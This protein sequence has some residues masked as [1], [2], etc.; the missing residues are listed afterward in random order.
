MNHQP[1]TR[2]LVFLQCATVLS[3]LGVAAWAYAATLEVQDDTESGSLNELLGSDVLPTEVGAAP[4]EQLHWLLVER[5]R[6]DFAQTQSITT[7]LRDE[8]LTLAPQLH[9]P[10]WL[11]QLE[12]RAYLARLR[13]GV[14]H[15]LQEVASGVGYDIP[16]AEHALVDAYI[17]YFSGRGREFFTKWLGRAARYEPI[18]RPILQQ[19]GLPQ[20]IIYLAMIESGLSS[21]A[22]SHAKA[23]GFWQFM[24]Q[25][26]RAYKLSST[27]WV[28]ARS[29]FI[30]ATHA[31]ATYL[32][33]L[34]KEFDDWHL[35][36]AAYNGGRGR[37]S[38]ALARTGARDFWEL[39]NYPQ[40]L[41]QE[42]RH[43]VPK[44]I[45][46][47]IVA[48]NA[49]QYGFNN[50]EPLSPLHYDEVTVDEPVD[51]HLVA[52]SLGTSVE[53]LRTLNPSLLQDVTP[54]GKSFA[55]RVPRGRG[56]ETL[57]WLAD[58]PASERLRYHAHT[59]AVGESLW[60]VAR[61]YGT[62]VPAI[63]EFNGITNPKRLRPGM[64]LI[65]P[66]PRDKRLPAVASG[67]TT[68][69][70]QAKASTGNGTPRERHVVGPGETLW[71]I[72]RRYGVSVDRL[73]EWN[74]RDGNAIVVGETLEIF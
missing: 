54:P 37:V 53:E 26:A 22:L 34:H 38:R 66:T 70:P 31:A 19:H 52:R 58:L 14:H 72:S 35:A 73:R 63:R 32:T 50:V 47:A 18:M 15:S 55:L 20:D 29:D 71:A 30:E 67:G 68:K 2:H 5:L 43:Y 10:H 13:G 59:L 46:A 40:A 17:D 6:T 44:I 60:T 64:T 9:D 12:R 57:A 23:G 45:A 7:R 11:A 48:K 3:C 49:Q 33:Y 4:Q 8:S 62:R 1:T 16:L 69:R 42:T 41:P 39:L 56:E 24:P 36:W 61:R 74:G 25:T 21:R 27:F 51:L 28:D 65:I